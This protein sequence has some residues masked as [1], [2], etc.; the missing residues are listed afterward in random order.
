[1]RTAFAGPVPRAAW[2]LS[3]AALTLILSTAAG[4]NNGTIGLYTDASGSTCSFSGNDPGVVTAYV[5]VRPG[6][7]GFMAVRFSVPIPSCFGG[8]LLEDQAI[9]GYATWGESQT[10]ITVA[11][12]VCE[13]TPVHILTISYM[14]TGSTSS[15]CAYPVVPELG[16]S[17]IEAIGCASQE[18][19]L[20]GS[21]SHF[22][23]DASCQCSAFA[24]PDVPSQPDPLDG[25]D[26]VRIYTALKWSGNDYDGDL[27]D[28]DVYLGTTPT[29]PL[30]AAHVTQ[31]TLQPAS[32]LD[33]LTHYYWYVVA[34][35][36]AGHETTGLTW[37][38]TTRLAN[39]PPDPPQLDVPGDGTLV[40]GIS[41]PL[42][43]TARDFD[44]DPL[45]YDVYIG[46]TMPL[47]PLATNLRMPAATAPYQ[48]PGHGSYMWQVIVRDSYG[49]ETAGDIWTFDTPAFDHPQ[50]PWAPD[51]ADLQ[52]GVSDYS[53]LTWND[54]FANGSL[55]TYDLYLNDELLATNLTAPTHKFPA[56]LGYQTAN[57]WYVVAHNQGETR[58]GNTWRFSRMGLPRDTPFNPQPSYVGV[59]TAP[60]TLTWSVVSPHAGVQYDVR[61]GTGLTPDVVARVSQ[62][63]FVPDAQPGTLY[64]WRV[65]SVV[66]GTRTLG[67]WWIFVYAGLTD[68]NGTVP[69]LF[70]K[71]NATQAPDG[72]NVS[73]KLASDEAMESYTLFRGVQGAAQRAA[74]SQGPVA[75][76]A[77]S[78]LDHDAAPGA[79]YEYQLL[80]RA[81]SGDEFQSPLATAQR[82][83]LEL[84]LGCNHPNPF[85]PQ[86][87]I[88]Y[89]VPP[90]ESPVRVR[91]AV[92][93]AAGRLVRVLVDENQAGGSREAVWNGVDSA[94]R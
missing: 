32:A 92:Y 71:F 19:E 4:A 41:V 76:S 53:A 49:H 37:E 82:A 13:P 48:Y 58:V 23:S 8:S 36:A 67:P 33:E 60:P 56:G 25:R 2:F 55:T 94:G 17:V 88:P 85:N 31:A 79:R 27:A 54:G 64:Y 26:G 81:S 5:V 20:T 62:P 84:S 51:P 78:Y 75:E 72:I 74:I 6:P 16:F 93:D 10:G 42:T 1:M 69:V 57:Y 83:G 15:C 38:F 11:T 18:I 35:D 59:V 86:T 77:G 30:V 61:F 66:A 65:E 47:A 39:S 90:S 91:L 45:Q 28:F 21:T 9:P 46:T 40:S 68:G 87:I 70:T 50:E 3:A 89:A 22:N 43:W 44:H 12:G 34:R 24:P 63:S 80:V 14:R 7:D 29:P 52:Q 73:W